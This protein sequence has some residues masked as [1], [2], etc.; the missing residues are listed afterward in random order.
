M[1]NQRAKNKVHYGGFV[2]RDFLRRVRRQAKRAGMGRNVFGF[3]A[4]LMAREIERLERE[5]K[6]EVRVVYEGAG[7]SSRY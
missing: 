4:E 1:P 7:N 6:K 2:T 3:G 5:E